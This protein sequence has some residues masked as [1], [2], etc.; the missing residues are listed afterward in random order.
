MRPLTRPKEKLEIEQ[1]GGSM[2]RSQENGLGEI[3]TK[4][5][6]RKPQ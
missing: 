4:L 5:E 1:G 6:Q 3:E 2:R